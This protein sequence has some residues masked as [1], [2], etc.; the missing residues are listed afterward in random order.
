LLVGEKQK[1]VRNQQIGGVVV[2]NKKKYL[3]DD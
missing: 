3:E 2:D 1:I